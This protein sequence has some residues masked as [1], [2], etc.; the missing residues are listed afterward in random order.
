MDVLFVTPICPPLRDADLSAMTALPIFTL[1]TYTGICKAHHSPYS[2][3]L[4]YVAW[5]YSRYGRLLQKQVY[6]SYW[7]LCWIKSSKFC[8]LNH[9][10][11]MFTK[12]D[13]RFM[14]YPTERH[15][16]R[17]IRSFCAPSVRNGNSAF[18]WRCWGIF[19]NFLF[20]APNR[21]SRWA[22]ATDSRSA[23][24]ANQL[25]HRVRLVSSTIHQPPEGFHDPCMDRDPGCYI[26]S[27][28]CR[29]WIALYFETTLNTTFSHYCC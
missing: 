10:L 7:E 5:R 15:T 22:W 27:I 23:Y 29:L 24:S 11:Q 21:K 16:F 12:S 19:Q 14:L 20:T 1:H 18:A 25:S 17:A 13:F 4:H 9:H 6:G 26:S 8:A 2:Q 28:E 3:L